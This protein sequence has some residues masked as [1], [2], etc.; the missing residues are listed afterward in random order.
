MACQPKPK[1]ELGHLVTMALSLQ[2]IAQDARRPWHPQ[3]TSAHLCSHPAAFLVQTRHGPIIVSL[4]CAV[5]I[6]ASMGFCA[7]LV[8]IF[9]QIM[10]SAKYE[11]VEHVVGHTGGFFAPYI[12]WL[13]F[14]IGFS[15]I[16]GCIVSF[17]APLAAGSGIPETKTYLNGVHI[18]GG[19]CTPA[20]SHLIG[21]AAVWHKLLEAAAAA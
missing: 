8:D 6:G 17:V 2:S 18:K 19:C 9:L 13:C 10:N 4:C 7:F 1:V 14:T 3:L 21:L 16:S 5:F 11:A 20:C 12:V 15:T